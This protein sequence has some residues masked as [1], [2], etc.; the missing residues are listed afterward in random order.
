MFAGAL[1]TEQYVYLFVSGKKNP[2]DYFANIGPIATSTPTLLIKPLLFHGGDTWIWWRK[3]KFDEIPANR[4]A[5]TLF[6]WVDHDNHLQIMELPCHNWDPSIYDFSHQLG[7][8]SKAP[9][10]TFPAMD[11]HTRLNTGLPPLNHT[12]SKG[13]GIESLRTSSSDS[14]NASMRRLPNARS[15]L[16]SSIWY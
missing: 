12:Y 1:A 14:A 15:A 3:R 8:M 11:I 16:I 10:G 5:T 2:S 4:G 13:Y 7:T 9:R 6:A